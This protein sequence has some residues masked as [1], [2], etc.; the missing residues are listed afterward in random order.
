MTRPS[1][2][3]TQR[4]AYLWKQL[5]FELMQQLYTALNW[6]PLR[7]GSDYCIYW[8]KHETQFFLESSAARVQSAVVHL[9]AV[10]VFKQGIHSSWLTL[11]NYNQWLS[12]AGFLGAGHFCPAWDS[13][14]RQFLLFGSLWGWLSFLSG[15]IVWALFTQASFFLPFLYLFPLPLPFIFYLHPHLVHLLHF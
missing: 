4:S 3:L 5:D 2:H 13:C 8:R 12:M 7:S 6:C 10:K 1:L 14:K 11:S 9:R 15:T